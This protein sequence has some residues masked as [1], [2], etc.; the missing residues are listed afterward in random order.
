MAIKSNKPTYIPVA[1]SM[2]IPYSWNTSH[3]STFFPFPDI[4]EI[5]KLFDPWA[6]FISHSVTMP[7]LW[8]VSALKV[9]HQKFQKRC[10][11]YESR[12]IEFDT[13]TLHINTLDLQIYRYVTKFSK[14]NTSHKSLRFWRSQWE[15]GSEGILHIYIYINW[16]VYT[17]Y[18]VH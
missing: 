9:S 14:K 2:T 13:P 8:F 12:T 15:L 6:L 17:V 10:T 11:W 5:F 16:I 1:K 3:S 4:L 18:S 7:V